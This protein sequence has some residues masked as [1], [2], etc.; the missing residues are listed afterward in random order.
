M[1]IKIDEAVLRKTAV[2]CEILSDANKR[3][4]IAPSLEQGILR[5]YM[6]PIPQDDQAAINRL[7]GLGICL[8][9]DHI[10]KHAGYNTPDVITGGFLAG[11]SGEAVYLA[12]CKFNSTNPANNFCNM[13]KFRNLVADKFCVVDTNFWNIYAPNKKFFV[14]FPAQKAD[15]AKSRIRKLQKASEGAEQSLV[16]QFTVCDLT[17]FR[18]YFT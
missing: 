13:K 2:F 10:V 3:N 4:N 14:I 9:G 15:Q 6:L 12:E 5:E 11:E 7:S 16:E 1:Q 8:R 17:E 18:T